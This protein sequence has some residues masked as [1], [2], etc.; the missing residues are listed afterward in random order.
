MNQRVT[1]NLEAEARGKRGLL[2][3]VLLIFVIQVGK[4]VPLD[5][6]LH[7]IL[8]LLSDLEIDKI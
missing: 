8:D 4:F 5:G 3:L 1:L 2:I 6:A 7:T